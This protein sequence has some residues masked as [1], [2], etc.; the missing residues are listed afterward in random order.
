MLEVWLVFVL[1]CICSSS[2]SAACLRLEQISDMS[3]IGCVV[4]DF[5]NSQGCQR[6]RPQPV[7]IRRTVPA[8][9]CIFVS[10]SVTEALMKCL[11]AKSGKSLPET[12]L[13]LL[14][15][16]VIVLSTPLIS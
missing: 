11:H 5:L 1:V 2:S 16:A 4:L 9:M 10:S 13:E 14:W 12:V 6:P 3:C 8:P 7:R 15:F